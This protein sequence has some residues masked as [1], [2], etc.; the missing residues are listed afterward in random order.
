MCQNTQVMDDKDVNIARQLTPEL[1]NSTLS[2][3]SVPVTRCQTFPSWL[4]TDGSHS[5]Y[6][7]PDILHEVWQ[8]FGEATVD[9]FASKENVSTVV[10]PQPGRRLCASAVALDTAVC[11]PPDT[12]Y[13]ST[14]SE[15]V[16]GTAVMDADSSELAQCNVVSGNDQ[17]AD[18]RPMAHSSRRMGTVTGS[19]GQSLCLR[20]RDSSCWLGSCVIATMGFDPGTRGPMHGPF[21]AHCGNPA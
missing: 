12:L 17:Y 14:L 15:S 3:Q 4:R 5:Q 18:V 1:V 21:R 8:R 16:R 19:G 9:L 13:P 2:S 6:L 11:F 10:L 20:P 7:H